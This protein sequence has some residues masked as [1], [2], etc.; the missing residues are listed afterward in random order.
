MGWSAADARRRPARPAESALRRQQ[1]RTRPRT[2]GRRA[3]SRAS[4]KAIQARAYPISANS[5]F[6]PSKSELLRTRGLSGS[7][8]IPAPSKV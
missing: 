8:A 3:R 1:C 5:N 7:D 6:E 2:A 4:R